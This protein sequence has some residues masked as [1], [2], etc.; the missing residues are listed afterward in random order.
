MRSQHRSAKTFSIVVL[1]RPSAP[2]ILN[3]TNYEAAIWTIIWPLLIA[4]LHLAPVFRRSLFSAF[5]P[6]LQPRSQRENTKEQTE[7]GRQTQLTW[8]SSMARWLLGCYSVIHLSYC[9]CLCIFPLFSEDVGLVP[10]AE[11][12]RQKL[13]D[14]YKYT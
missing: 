2:S 14:F 10:G 4:R 7:K 13:E 6:A 12:H 11:R 1:D 9:S 8:T 5:I 3:I